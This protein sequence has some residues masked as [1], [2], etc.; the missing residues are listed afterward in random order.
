MAIVP[1]S[2]QRLQLSTVRI[3]IACVWITAISASLF[4][5]MFWGRY[6]YTVKSS[7]CRPKDGRFILFLGIACFAIPLS[8]MVFCYVN[9]FLKVQRH[10]QMI[11]QSQRDCRFKTE[12]KTTKIV[13]TVLAIFI[14]LWAPFAVLYMSSP[15][16]DIMDTIP[17]SAFKFC[18]FL[19][20]VHSMYNP[21]I[22]FTMIRTFRKTAMNLLRTLFSCILAANE[23][24]GFTTDPLCSE[25]ASYSTKIV[26]PNRM[27]LPMQIPTNLTPEDS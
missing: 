1:K 17:T 23:E 6:Y 22:Y 20:T 13:F 25:K 10:K 5:I 9:I 7:L 11:A 26:T 19:T 14:I 12:L 16:S 2:G 21:I 4:P 18:G 8:T 24:S 3:F 27:I 15:K